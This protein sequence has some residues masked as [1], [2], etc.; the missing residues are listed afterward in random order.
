MV[1]RSLD[2][3]RSEPGNYIGLTIIE[4]MHG[5]S[6]FTPFLQD[7]IYVGPNQRYRPARRRSITGESAPDNY[8]SGNRKTSV[9]VVE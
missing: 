4:S 1:D 6:R 7:C 9:E 5:S 8:R 3:T 2:A